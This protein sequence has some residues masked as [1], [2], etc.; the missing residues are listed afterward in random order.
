MVVS[1][2]TEI[3]IGN[4]KNAPCLVHVIV[5]QFALSIGVAILVMARINKGGRCYM[6]D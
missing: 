3:V 2:Y 4:L 5:W 1:E 6:E